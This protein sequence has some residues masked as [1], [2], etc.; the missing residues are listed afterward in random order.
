MNFQSRSARASAAG[1]SRAGRSGS[2]TR[3]RRAAVRAS[4]SRLPAPSAAAADSVRRGRMARRSSAS[5]ANRRRQVGR[6]DASWMTV[7]AVAAAVAGQLD[8]QRHADGRVV[9]KRAVR[10]LAVLAKR[11]AMI[12]DDDDG[13]RSRMPIAGECVEQPADRGVGVGD[14]AVVGRARMGGGKLGRRL[15]TASADRTGAARRKARARLGAGCWRSRRR[16]GGR[17]R[18]PRRS[19]APR[20]HEIVVVAVEAATETEGRLQR[21]A[22]D[23]R[24]GG[25]AGGLAALRQWSAR[26]ARRRKPSLVRTP[27]FAG[28]SPVSIVACAGSVSGT[29]VI[30]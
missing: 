26:P 12:G 23:E 8:N 27:C 9:E 29:W 11:L 25:V 15:R 2:R 20:A 4:P 16:R 30:A 13:A 6:F 5:A 1:S 21:I 7:G 22:A 19:S 3:R 14:L 10:A 24:A 28:C 18:P 17:R